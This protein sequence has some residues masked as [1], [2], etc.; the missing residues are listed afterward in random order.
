MQPLA[1]LAHLRA[2][3]ESYI[4]SFQFYRNPQIGEWVQGRQDAGRLSWRE[5]FLT[6]AANYE[7]GTPFADLLAEGLVSSDATTVFTKDPDDPTSG[8]IDPRWHQDQAI[9]H[10]DNGANVLVTT[11]TGSG[12]SFCFYIPIVSDALEIKPSV[13]QFRGPMA[14]I[15]YPMNALANSQYEDMSQRLA[16]SGITICNYTGDLPRTE[17]GALA[18]FRDLYGRDHPYDS[19]VIDRDALHTK[20]C[21]ILLTNFKMLE[22]ALLRN[23]DAMLF[24][25]AEA[26]GRLRWLVL[27]EMHTYSGRQGADMAML[28]RR[29]KNRTGTTDTLR[30]I[31]TSATVDS[32]PVTASTSIAAFASD[33]F[34]EPF[35]PA[36]V[37]A[38]R[39][40]DPI[41][42]DPGDP[43]SVFPPRPC[44]GSLVES[45]RDVDDDAAVLQLLG[46]AVCGTTGTPTVDEVRRT[47]TVGWVER[48]LRAAPRVHSLDALVERYRIELR[49][50]ASTEDAVVDIEAALMVGAA[51]KVPGPRGTPVGLLTPKVHGFFSQGL[52][53]TACAW[54][55]PEDPHLSEVGDATCPTCSAA[56]RPGVPTFPL[57]FC[58]SCGQE[59]LAAGETALGWDPLPFLDI[60]DDGTRPV[61]LTTGDAWD[62]DDVQIDPDRLKLDGSPRKNQEGYVPIRVAMCGT[63]GANDPDACGHADMREMARVPRPFGL[64][65][66]CGVEYDGSFSEFNKFFQ[67]GTVGRATATDVLVSGLLG[68]LPDDDRKV[69]AFSDNQ[70]DTSFQTAHL[71]SLGRRFHLRRAVV[72]G[73]AATGTVDAHNAKA[74]NEVA[75]AA[76]D[77]MVDADAVPMFAR[78]VEGKQTK[79]AASAAVARAENLY[80]R[81]LEAGVLMESSGNPRKT[82]PN[83]EDTGLLRVSYETFDASAFGSDTDD[84][85]TLD[86]DYPDLATL[87]GALRVDLLRVILDTIRRAQ[88]IDGESD[89]AAARV[90]MDGGSFQRDVLAD[91]NTEVLFHGSREAPFRY[92]VFSDTADTGKRANVRRLAGKDG[93]NGTTKTVR[94]LVREA[95]REGLGFV[96]PTHTDADRDATRRRVS[97]EA[98]TVVQQAVQWLADYRYL[99]ESGGHTKG[100]AVA[101]EKILYWIDTDPAQRR[102]PRCSVLFRFVGAERACPRC[103][104]TE[105][106]PTPL[107]AWDY[108]RTEYSAPIA[109][110]PEVLAAEHTGAIDGEYRKEIEKNFRSNTHRLN[111]VV[112]TPT[113]ELGVDIGNLAAVH[114]RNVPPSPANYAQRQGRAGRASQPSIVTT[115]CGSQG[116]SGPHDQH[117]F[118]FPDRMIAG[119]IAAPRFNTDNEALVRAHMHSIV[120]GEWGNDFYTNP[121]HVWLELDEVAGA[122]GRIKPA[123]RAD[124]NLYL[125]TSRDELIGLEQTVFDGILGSASVPVSVI[126]DVV[127][128]FLLDFE[129]EWQALS[130]ELHQAKTE[131]AEIQATQQIGQSSSTDQR[132]ADALTGRIGSIRDGDGDYY[133][134]GWLSQRAFLPT[135]AFPRKAVALHLAGLRKRRIRGQSVALREFAPNNFVYHRGRRYEVVKAT[136]GPGGSFA[137]AGRLG[138]CGKCGNYQLGARAATATVCPKCGTPYMDSQAGSLKMQASI[139]IPSGYAT[140]RETVGA[141]AEDRRRQGYNIRA[142]FRMNPTRRNG[143]EATAPT[144]LNLVLT[145]GARGRLLQ[146][147]LGLNRSDEVGFSVCTVCREWNPGAEHFGG[148]KDCG[149]EDDN[150]IASIA[151]HT[152]ADHDMALI[153]AV[154]PNDTDPDT[155]A[156]S[157]LYSLTAGIS[158]YFGIDESELDGRIFPDPTNPMGR[159]ILIYELDEGGIGVLTRL[160]EE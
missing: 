85:D 147:N 120:I 2:T 88:A 44:P 151:I 159:R 108:F 102:C 118:R 76:W 20:G 14:V 133:S 16:G 73:L 34:G 128:N 10:A 144:G 82:Q 131:L 71:N 30:C 94:W 92:T 48:A 43:S 31:G 61:Y 3:Y 157:L 67:V 12:K 129:A 41:T 112:C 68:E 84:D 123:W 23:S 153:E 138:M 17:E 98:R 64:C 66:H 79:A 86:A 57:V 69:M 45:A 91:L 35:D 121:N 18:R 141:D 135:Y 143:W 15:V 27:D 49:P 119:K 29:F 52:P 54:A 106:K 9:R 70:Q 96:L 156:Y 100:H 74:A 5:P 7:D 26:G 113:M 97:A 115:F 137:D 148:D 126:A 38:D 63:C 99:V 55:A 77:A 25:N 124:L 105:L 80:R 32:D 134:L 37:V 111:V 19:E 107:Q 39:F 104:K 93:W 140:A 152:E 117:F 122:S 42:I 75:K 47:R 139:E 81:Y 8:P 146:A 59:Y 95:K 62:E 89:T 114:M 46:P 103:V 136:L 130:V 109:D 142:G 150:K 116:R 56:G 145:F 58:Q 33:L 160:Q 65:C 125:E 4:K 83:L 154:A 127:D 51:V 28:V 36:H 50:G 22:Y 158:V 110:R 53:V 101:Q 72:A 40:A 6:L 155:F 60:G 13:D 24:K 149:D 21:D 78:A 132:R 1:S 87:P 90:F 11:G